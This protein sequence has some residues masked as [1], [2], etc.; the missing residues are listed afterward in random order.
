MAAASNEGARR[1]QHRSRREFRPWVMG[2]DA[3]CRGSCVGRRRLRLPCQRPGRDEG[4]SEARR[5]QRRHHRGRPGFADL[6]G[7]GRRVINRTIK[8]PRCKIAY[9]IGAPQAIAALAWAR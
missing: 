8:E 6:Q 3:A 5:Q 1:S 7:F 4:N 2:D 9:Q